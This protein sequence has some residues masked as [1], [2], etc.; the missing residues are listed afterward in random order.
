MGEIWK[1]GRSEIQEV[2]SYKY[3]GFTFT[4]QNSFTKHLSTLTSKAQVTANA[5]WW[6]L[7]RADIGS[8][9]RRGYLMNTLVQ[10]IFMYGAEIW[11]WRERQIVETMAGRYIKMML[12]VSRCTPAY[13]W[14]MESGRRKLEVEARWRALNYLV[15]ILKIGDER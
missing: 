8:L 14:R 6:I 1:Y 3:L 7:K 15:F 12:R 5:A 2:G 10:T 4:A 11:G 9:K 13:I